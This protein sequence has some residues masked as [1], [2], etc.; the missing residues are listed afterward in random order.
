[1]GC[2]PSVRWG[3]S[4]PKGSGDWLI[5]DSHTASSGP[6]APT[7]VRTC[8]VRPPELPRSSRYQDPAQIGGTQLKGHSLLPPTPTSTLMVGH[9]LQWLL[10]A[11]AGTACTASTCTSR[12]ESLQTPATWCK[13]NCGSSTLRP[14]MA[15]NLSECEA[16]C[17]DHYSSPSKSKNCKQG[18][19][20]YQTLGGCALPG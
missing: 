17:Q 9:R 6:G 19:V 20:Q 13:N 10:V 11:I 15:C 5:G 3:G 1:M 8:P 7:L 16:G 2:P 18:C 4:G 12:P 14:Y